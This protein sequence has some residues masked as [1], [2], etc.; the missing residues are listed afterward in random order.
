MDEEF[1]NLPEL[2][3]EQAA[4][5]E[6]LPEMTREQALELE[7][8]DRQA[9]IEDTGIIENPKI[10]RSPGEIASRVGRGIADAV[11]PALE[12]GA[13]TVGGLGGA[14]VTGGSP[15]GFAA[16]ATA[17]EQAMSQLLQYFGLKEEKSAFGNA[18]DTA[19]SAGINF[20]IPLAGKFL[21]APLTNKVLNAADE[22]AV[23]DALM[24]P[25]S[26]SVLGRTMDARLR[27]S[28]KWIT[29]SGIL[30]GATAF[31]AKT[32][33][34]IAAAGT[35]APKDIRTLS[36]NVET[37]LNGNP[38]TGQMGL[39]GQQEELLGRI[40]DAMRVFNEG[41]PYTP[42]IG[43]I[44]ANDL[45]AVTGDITKE[46]DRLAKTPNISGEASTRLQETL[47]GVMSD[48]QNFSGSAPKTFSRGTVRGDR[49]LITTSTGLLSPKDVNDVIKNLYVTAREYGGYAA[50]D[51]LDAVQKTN[52]REAAS[53]LQG[54]A[55]KLR[56]IRDDKIGEILT[57]VQGANG[58]EGITK[59]SVQ[60]VSDAIHNLLNFQENGLKPFSEAIVP[61]YASRAAMTENTTD[62][63]R[64][65][66]NREPWYSK[67]WSAAKSPFGLGADSTRRVMNTRAMTRLQKIKELRNNPSSPFFSAGQVLDSPAG[68]MG[69]IYLNMERKK[70]NPYAQALS[71]QALAHGT[72]PAA[73][74]SS[75][76]PRT[77]KGLD[78]NI[79]A[80]M[81]RFAQIVG[82]PA[83]VEQ[84]RNS[85]Q[86]GG[87]EE[88]NATIALMLKHMPEMS[89]YFA[90][91]KS[92]LLS[93]IDGKIYA[94]EDMA[95]A[96]QAIE[97][98]KMTNTEK[99][100]AWK[101]LWDNR[102]YTGK[103][104]GQPIMSEQ[105]QPPQMTFHPSDL[106]VQ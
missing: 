55:A 72:E 63:A 28:N 37:L 6:S 33:K 80:I 42:K 34:F 68:A 53:T 43:G 56:V 85:L 11:P 51:A 15:F 44:T 9:Q 49:N 26:Q 81:D 67:A 88:K 3:P 16:G 90:P 62:Q 22:G 5:Y 40:D 27:E 7:A 48:L 17:G 1:E 45:K 52:Y 78:A 93:E 84:A 77:A 75:L 100:L 79:P 99:A 83:A 101:E 61:R 24:Q 97:D 76:I 73:L 12:M 31:D 21:K 64:T 105:F 70:E 8:A 102:R 29:S 47:Q 60:N 58:L 95:A 39:I 71:N 66:F 10:L 98:S 35:K 96:A 2:S 23:S 92:G 103:P 57:K 74:E 50:D 87:R 46:I 18:A 104:L 106:F 54:L 69:G 32:G 59:D 13:S 91:S 65:A 19:I 25:M 4:E 20:G 30:D 86:F 89:R 94:K 41:S 82:D 14:A 38:A 36:S